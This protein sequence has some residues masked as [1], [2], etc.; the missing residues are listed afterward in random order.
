V[1]QAFIGLTV[2]IF[3]FGCSEEHS[4]PVIPERAAVLVQTTIT[5]QYSQRP[6]GPELSIRIVVS[7]D[8]PPLT[9]PHQ[10]VEHFGFEIRDAGDNV[11]LRYPANCDADHHDLVIEENG[12]VQR[13]YEIGIILPI[14]GYT[15]RGGL[16]EYE[17]EYPWVQKVLDVKQQSGFLT[18]RFYLRRTGVRGESIE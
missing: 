3:G 5:V 1:K 8:G 4:S 18:R 9:L 2:A 15:V 12:S 10:C 14:G 7:N 6:F 11:I 16:S 13:D 17:N